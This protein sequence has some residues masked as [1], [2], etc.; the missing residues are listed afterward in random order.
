MKVWSVWYA[1]CLAV[2]GLNIKKPVTYISSCSCRKAIP[3][4]AII[5][6]WRILRTSLNFL[7]R[8]TTCPDP[9]QVVIMLSLQVSMASADGRCTM[10]CFVI[11]LGVK[12]FRLSYKFFNISLCVSLQSFS[13]HY[14]EVF[15]QDSTQNDFRLD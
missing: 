2:K 10:L 13:V 4:G 11:I 3:W 8:M 1:V 15:S 12:F 14:T 6:W 7:S 5:S 9:G